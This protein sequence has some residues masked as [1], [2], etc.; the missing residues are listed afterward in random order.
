[1]RRKTSP[2]KDKFLQKCMRCRK[3]FYNASDFKEHTKRCKGAG[4]VDHEPKPYVPLHL[5]GK[6]AGQMPLSSNDD[7]KRRPRRSSG[8]DAAMG[9]G[10]ATAME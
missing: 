8:N 7:P 3:D 4:S 5:R 10:L 1:M 6:N 9:L 2:Q